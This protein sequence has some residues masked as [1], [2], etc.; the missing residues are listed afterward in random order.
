MTQINMAE[1]NRYIKQ[2]AING[3]TADEISEIVGVSR[4]RIMQI[5]KNFRIKAAKKS[6]KL[7]CEKAQEI[8]KELRAGTRQV[9][10]AEKCGVSRQYVNQI[11]KTLLAMENS[12]R[13]AD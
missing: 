12:K 5:L 11:K 9:Y 8:V 6:H 2:L 7:E 4:D 3:K 13:T 1:R 10:I